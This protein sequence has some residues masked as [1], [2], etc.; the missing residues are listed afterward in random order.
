M[1]AYALSTQLRFDSEDSW[2]PRQMQDSP[3]FVMCRSGT[4]VKLA[5]AKCARSLSGQFRTVVY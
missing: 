2:T 5:V 1:I 3:T 4:A